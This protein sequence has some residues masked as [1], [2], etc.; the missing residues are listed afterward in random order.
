ME[1]KLIIKLF[2]LASLVVFLIVIIINYIKTG[3]KTSRKSPK[4]SS[5]SVKDTSLV[6]NELSLLEQFKEIQNKGT[7]IAQ[8]KAPAATSTKPGVAPVHAAGSGA[9][10]TGIQESKSGAY[11]NG[12]AGQNTGGR[13]ISINSKEIK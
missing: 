6:N 13:K 4:A 2:T 5:G 1:F 9:T 10:V 3:K 11:D 12:Q 7:G 8:S